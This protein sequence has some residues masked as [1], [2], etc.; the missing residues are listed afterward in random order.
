M[1][2]AEF[3]G[4]GLIVDTLQM[5]FVACHAIPKL[6]ISQ[7]KELVSPFDITTW[8]LLISSMLTFSLIINLQTRKVKPSISSSDAFYGLFVLLLEKA[9]FVFDYSLV[10]SKRVEYFVAF[11]IPFVLLVLSN[12]YRGDNISRLTVEPA[13]L[14]FDRFETLVEHNFTAYTSKRKLSNHMIEKLN[15]T[16]NVTDD[17]QTISN[18]QFF[19]CV[20]DLWYQIMIQFPFPNTLKAYSQRLSNK[21]WLYLNHTRAY[22]GKRLKP[23]SKSKRKIKITGKTGKLK[24][25]INHLLQCNKSAVISFKSVALEAY[26]NLNH[27]KAPVFF[28]KDIIHE[29]MYGYGF[30]G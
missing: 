28:G 4:P 7:L 15:E 17:F 20:S 16:P 5:R 9:H 11:S 18:H 25:A 14:P 10:K 2:I 23:I 3:S 21:T 29:N 13:L 30:G 6:W 27:V 1:N 12:E 24:R 22:E 26:K 8:F 19:P